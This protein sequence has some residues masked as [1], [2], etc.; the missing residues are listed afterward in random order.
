MSAGKL[1]FWLSC[2]EFFSQLKSNSFYWNYNIFLLGLWSII[3]SVISS[4]A[5]V[6][7]RNSN[8][9]AASKKIHF[10]CYRVSTGT[11]GK[12]TSSP[13]P[14]LRWRW[15]RST[16]VASAA[17][18]DD[19]PLNKQTPGPQPCPGQ[20]QRFNRVWMIVGVKFLLPVCLTDDKRQAGIKHRQCL[21]SK[22][23][24]SKYIIS[25][26]IFLKSAQTIN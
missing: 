8:T 14:L 20:S 7:L 13:F 22:P 5:Y 1:H 2:S 3:I 18:G 15:G 24:K 12:A 16:S 11:T 26:N 6:S 4:D 9:R 19:L 23:A 10:H 25:I 21:F 17:R